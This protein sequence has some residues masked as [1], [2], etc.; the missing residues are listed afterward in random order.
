MINI[1]QIINSIN[2]YANKNIMQNNE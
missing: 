2:K 1:I